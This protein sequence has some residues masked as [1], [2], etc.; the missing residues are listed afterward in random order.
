[1]PGA[2]SPTKSMS[3]GSVTGLERDVTTGREI[4]TVNINQITTDLGRKRVKTEVVPFFRT[5]RNAFV[6]YV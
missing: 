1:M 6:M 3:S 5:S 4:L 2:V